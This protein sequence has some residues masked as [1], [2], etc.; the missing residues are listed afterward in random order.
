MATLN[1]NKKGV[2]E[3]KYIRV[4]ASLCN[5]TYKCEKRKQTDLLQEI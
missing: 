5:V 1:K 2:K 4:Y 3:Q